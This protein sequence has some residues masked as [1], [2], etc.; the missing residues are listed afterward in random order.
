MTNRKKLNINDVLNSGEKTKKAF[1][2]NRKADESEKG[3]V[4]EKT[5]CML[6]EKHFKRLNKELLQTLIDKIVKIELKKVIDHLLQKKE[7]PWLRVTDE[8]WDCGKSGCVKGGSQHCKTID[9]INCP[10]ISHYFKHQITWKL[11]AKVRQ[12]QQLQK[13]KK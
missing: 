11:S 5:A 4:I 1:V 13:R 9:F 10:A 2:K 12:A 3:Q 8:E 6:F 7:C